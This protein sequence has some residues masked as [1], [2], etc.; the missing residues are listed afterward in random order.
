MHSPLCIQLTTSSS[1]SLSCVKKTESDLSDITLNSDCI[2]AISRHSK[3]SLRQL[4]KLQKQTFSHRFIS[5]VMR[6]AVVTP[7]T[8]MMALRAADGDIAQAILMLKSEKQ[9]RTNTNPRIS[10]LHLNTQRRYSWPSSSST[11]FSNHIVVNTE[12]IGVQTDSN[13][14]C[15]F[16]PF[17]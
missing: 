11:M 17:C 12:D 13:L 3:H 4:W 15:C 2:A 5:I 16:L 6:Q 8:A 14:L 7:K 1:S 10:D 9:R